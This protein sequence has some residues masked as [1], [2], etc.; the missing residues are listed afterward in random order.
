MESHQGRFLLSVL[1]MGSTLLPQP[2]F[3]CPSFQLVAN[4]ALPK[5]GAVRLTEILRLINENQ[6]VL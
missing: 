2:V 1:D 6:G 5:G 4:Y 3:P